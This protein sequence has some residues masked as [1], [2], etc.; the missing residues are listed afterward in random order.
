MVSANCYVEAFQLL[1]LF[2]IFVL[3]DKSSKLDVPSRLIEHSV[4]L[5]ILVGGSAAVKLTGMITIVIP[6]T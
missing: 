2:A 1:E 5:L 3:L 4:L 6:L